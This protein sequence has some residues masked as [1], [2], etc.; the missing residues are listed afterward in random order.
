MTLDELFQLKLAVIRNDERKQKTFLNRFTNEIEKRMILKTVNHT[1]E[2]Y[3]RTLQ[4][5]KKVKELLERGA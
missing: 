5:W 2:T 4:I 3:E 1:I